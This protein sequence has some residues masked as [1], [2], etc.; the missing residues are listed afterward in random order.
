M[1][2]KFKILSLDGGGY[3]GVMSASVLH[4]LGIDCNSTF[5]M[6][7]GTSTGSILAGGLRVGYTPYDLL[8][9]YRARGKEIFPS[10]FN[11]AL[12]GRFA[13]L[14]RAKYSSEPLRKLL[15]EYF[16]DT[17]FAEVNKKL[18]VNSYNVEFSEF[19]CRRSWVYGYND[20]FLRENIL[21]SCSA[22]V[23][24]PSN[25][26]E[27][28]GGIVVNNPSLIAVAAAI[29][30]GYKLEDI[31]LLSIGTGKKKQPLVRIENKNFKIGTG[32]ITWATKFP[33]E[34]LEGTSQVIDYECRLLLGENYLRLNPDLELA[35][36]SI[37]NASIDQYYS[38]KTDAE[39][40]MCETLE[41]VVI[42]L[43]ATTTRKENARNFLMC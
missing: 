36:D 18:L 38:L 42:G 13:G 43:N 10:I 4:E 32:A 39:K 29:K 41:S 15:K 17:L 14:F 30:L 3:R 23:Y 11:R 24:F 25:G 40:Y 26:S 31:Q 16:S 22:P 6:I 5:D 28:D 34:T 1:N 8:E 9:F 27:V 33:S 21:S 37:D 19:I 20:G 2:T 35:N 7:A 12:S